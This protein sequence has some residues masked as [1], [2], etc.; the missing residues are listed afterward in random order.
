[1]CSLLQSSGGVIHMYIG[2]ESKGLLLY[3]LDH[4]HLDCKIVTYIQKI[5]VAQAN[6]RSLT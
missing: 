4:L 5:Q 3:S 6:S 2:T 1:M